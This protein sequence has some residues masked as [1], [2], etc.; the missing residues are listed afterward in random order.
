MKGTR[1]VTEIDQ[2]GF[3]EQD[4][5][6]NDYSTEFVELA[7]K[8]SGGR[9]DDHVTTYLNRWTMSN[10]VKLE[11]SPYE[12]SF[13]D[14][15]N[16]DTIKQKLH[17]CFGVTG[18]LGCRIVWNT[19]PFVQGLYILAYLPPGVPF[20]NYP[21]YLSGCPHVLINLAE[22]TSAELHV[23]Y[24]GETGYIP[25]SS[26]DARL[27][28]QVGSFYLAPIV[29]ARDGSGT[30]EIPA[31]FYFRLHNAK[32]FGQ[33]ADIP[34]VQ[35]AEVIGS[36]AEAVK[37][38]KVVSSSLGKVSDWLNSNEDDNI[39]GSMSRVGG[40][41]LGGAKKIADLLGWSK[42]LNINTP[43][44]VVN[45]PYGDTCTTDAVYTGMK[46]ANN[47]DAGLA[48]IDM[49]DNGKDQMLIRNFCRNEFI[50]F[51]VEWSSNTAAGSNIGTIPYNPRSWVQTDGKKKIMNHLTYLTAVLFNYWRGAIKLTIQPV[52]TKFHS[53]RLRIVFNPAHVT[54]N[55]DY[56]MQ[57]YTY[58][59]IVD[60]SDPS[61]W[62]IEIPYVS[63]T[64]WRDSDI[65]A[66]NINI[67]V[68]TEL[69]VS[70]AVSHSVDLVMLVEPSNSFEVAVTNT[71]L[72]V[73]A[74]K[75]YERY[76][77]NAIDTFR[78]PETQAI[79]FVDSTSKSTDAHNLSIGDPVRSLRACLKRFF[80]AQTF[81]PKTLKFSLFNV[82]FKYADN[83]EDDVDIS[84]DF[85]TLVAMNYA[86]WRGSMRYT[87]TGPGVQRVDFTE[88]PL[89]V[90]NT[91]TNGC[92]KESLHLPLQSQTTIVT[93]RDTPLKV[94]LPYYSRTICSNLRHFTG[95][96]PYNILPTTG[97]AAVTVLA[98]GTE[99]YVSRA[100]GDDFDLGFLIGA[101][102][103]NT[104]PVSPS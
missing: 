99:T 102:I 85:M 103:M 51:K 64:P 2:T 10:T 49:S 56:E 94:E 26:Y 68:E 40:W 80:L 32:T 70:S 104:Q 60:L 76:A 95:T 34:S 22:S 58:N 100:G 79:E 25:L 9:H 61:S 55:K 41:M 45:M 33:F 91:S 92:S 19:Q 17:G 44:P 69:S 93:P 47:V 67:F 98:P 39:V 63:L 88:F 82:P 21:Q 84:P 54:T 96:A 52:M 37:K 1:T 42:P 73:T 14:Y 23:P 30:Q 77:P 5:E 57:A 48:R 97:A 8:T 46:F 20:E 43:M 24:V 38:S 16:F 29:A 90:T 71:G 13:S 27:A 78:L 86:F 83:F 35:A 3:L 87:V 59:W 50:P 66:G 7:A 28:K 89:I 36:V 4:I 81:K 15:M 11:A 12:L 75:T 62:T 18:T 65:T 101:P 72:T 31:R 6:V 74:D 53:G